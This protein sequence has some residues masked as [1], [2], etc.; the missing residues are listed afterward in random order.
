MIAIFRCKHDDDVELIQMPSQLS[1]AGTRHKWNDYK[2]YFTFANIHEQFVIGL[3]LAFDI[4]YTRFSA[5][6]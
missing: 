1:K 4:V 5:Y 3:S 2:L 6:K